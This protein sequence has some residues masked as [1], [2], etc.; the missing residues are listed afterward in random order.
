[1]S[2][3]AETGAAQRRITLVSSARDAVLTCTVAMPL[4]AST[5]AK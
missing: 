2:E 5:D 3:S 4:D 1:M